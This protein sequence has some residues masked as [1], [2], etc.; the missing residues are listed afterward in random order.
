MAY[1]PKKPALTYEIILRDVKAGNL[2]PVYYLMGAESYY[3]DRVSDYIVS[4]LLAPEER[5]FNL[6]TLFGPE[7]N[8]DAVIDT[9]KG[10]PMGARHLV[11]LV[12]EAQGLKELERLSFYLKRP[13]ESTVLIFCHKNGTL[14]RRKKIAV[15]IEKAGVLYESAKLRDYQL[16]NFI[17]GYMRRKGVGIEADAVAMIAEHVG[18]DLNRLAGEL[19]KICIALPRGQRSVDRDLVADNIGVSRDFNIF[20]LQEALSVKDAGR[21]MQI[22]NYFDKNKKANP[23]QLILPS[24]FRFFSNIMLAFYAPGKTEQ[25]IATWLGLSTW[26]VGKNVMPAM[27]HYSGVKVMNILGELRRTD[28]RSKGVGNPSVPNGELMRE[29]FYFILH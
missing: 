4:T 25:S 5:D 23:I 27:K 29:L 22:V 7:V 14:D 21:V 3:I 16:P 2:K 15:E 10:F 26:Q 11:V 20:E 12:K 19:D 1:P 17:N 13:Q 24:L 9:A 8:I 18:A 6:V 28:A